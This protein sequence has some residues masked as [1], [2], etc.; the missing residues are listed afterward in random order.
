MV[1][2]GVDDSSQA[3]ECVCREESN[4]KSRKQNISGKLSWSCGGSV[5]SLGDLL[6]SVAK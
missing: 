4:R 2:G 1:S 3:E 6:V 5:W